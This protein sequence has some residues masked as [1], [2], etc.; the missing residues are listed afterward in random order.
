MAYRNREGDVQS[1]A[2]PLLARAAKRGRPVVV[3]VETMC[4][5]PPRVSFCGQT[6]A[7]LASALD[8]LSLSLRSSPAFAGLAV[9][10]YA[11]W[12]Q[13]ERHAR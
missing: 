7:E 8:H 11:S 4:I 1:L 9:H 10:N 13:L 6:P 12:A 5:D 3:A 2:A